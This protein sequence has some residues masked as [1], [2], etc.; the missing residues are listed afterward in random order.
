MDIKEMEENGTVDYYLELKKYI[1]YFVNKNYPLSKEDLHSILEDAPTDNVIKRQETYKILN[2]AMETALTN[3]ENRNTQI[4]DGAYQQNYTAYTN[5][6]FEQELFEIKQEMLGKLWKEQHPEE[7]LQNEQIEQINEQESTLEENNNT[8]QSQDGQEIVQEENIDSESSGQQLVNQ[9]VEQSE[10]IDI[11]AEE[12]SEVN[13]EINQVQKDY[14][15]I[16]Q[17]PQQDFDNSI[18]IGE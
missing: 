4:V 13:R 6:N 1:N 2:D 14:E 11:R 9:V 16:Q 10:E 3:V 7:Q 18:S 17:Q 15:Q 5:Q 12:I 8:L